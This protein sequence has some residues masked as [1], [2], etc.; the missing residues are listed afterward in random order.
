MK[1]LLIYALALTMVIGQAY[2]QTKTTKK[3]NEMKQDTAHY[4]FKLSDK[5]TRQKA[6]YS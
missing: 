6:A 3:G 4:T 1:T 2:A 5:V